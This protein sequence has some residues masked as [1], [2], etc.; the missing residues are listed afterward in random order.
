MKGHQEGRDAAF[1]AIGEAEALRHKE[2]GDFSAEEAEYKANI[3]ALE[4]A[5]GAIKSGMV[6]GS[7]AK[8]LD[9]NNGERRACLPG[10]PPAAGQEWALAL[11]Q[12]SLAPKARLANHLSLVA[13]QEAISNTL[14]VCVVMIDLPNCLEAALTQCSMCHDLGHVWLRL[15][16]VP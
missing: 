12:R 6:D 3:A 2:N 14:V 13:Q 16:R 15:S 10:L 5:I 1:H 11:L 8:R 7:A 4:G 9:H